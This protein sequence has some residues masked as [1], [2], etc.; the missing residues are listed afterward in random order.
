MGILIGKEKPAPVPSPI[1]S[2]GSLSGS[3]SCLLPTGKQAGNL[4]SKCWA[5][6]PHQPSQGWSS[7]KTDGLVSSTQKTGSLK[8]ILRLGA[9]LPGLRP[10][11]SGCLATVG[12]TRPGWVPTASP[13][14][15]SGDRMCA[16]LWVQS[17]REDHSRM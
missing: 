9:A 6:L 13:A 1:R 7:L 16:A 4:L 15:S 10:P 2:P 12:V 3:H 5:I 11:V 8:S 14:S 17:T